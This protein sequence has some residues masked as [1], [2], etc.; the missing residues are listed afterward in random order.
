MNGA[1]IPGMRG[2]ARPDGPVEVTLSQEQ[3]QALATWFPETL[4]NMQSD[5][6]AFLDRLPADCVAG[7]EFYTTVLVMARTIER[8]YR[9]VGEAY[10]FDPGNNAACLNSQQLLRLAQEHGDV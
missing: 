1:G 3:A 8:V 4:A 7:R 10:G 9:T 2:K 5:A 6:A